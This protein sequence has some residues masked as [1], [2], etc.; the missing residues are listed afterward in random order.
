MPAAPAVDLV[1]RRVHL[2]P[3]ARPL[4]AGRQVPA[5]D[6]VGKPVDH[7]A[8][9]VDAVVPGAA[10]VG[11]RAVDVTGWPGRRPERLAGPR[12]WAGWP[13]VRGRRAEEVELP[14]HAVASR[15]GQV[16][17]CGRGRPDRASWPSTLAQAP[18]I[19]VRSSVRLRPRASARVS[20][21]A[22]RG[23]DRFGNSL[24]MLTIVRTSMARCTPNRWTF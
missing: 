22:Q 5:V 11:E 3:V 23:Q 10:P 6:R 2:P 19:S 1:H 16:S 20:G 4:R 7:R 15:S 17:C 14:G 9:G 24:A 13:A 8:A 21:P 12:Q 18:Q